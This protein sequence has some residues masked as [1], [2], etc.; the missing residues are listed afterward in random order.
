[1]SNYMPYTVQ[2]HNTYTTVITIPHSSIESIDFI[3]GNDPTETLSSVYNRL[4]QKPQVL[5]NG[6]LFTLAT[7]QNILS[8]IDEGREQNYS[9]NYEGI[10]I[11]KADVTTLVYGHDKD[12]WK[13]F[14]A[15][16]PMLVKDGTAITQYTQA[17]EINY[18][19]A[20]QSIGITQDSDVVIITVDKPGIKFEGLAKIMVQY[21]VYYGMA[22]DGGGSVRTM[23]EGKVINTPTENRPVDNMVAIY[24][25]PD[26]LTCVDKDDIG[27]WALDDVRYCYEHE[28]MNGD[29]HNRFRPQDPITRQ[30][31]ACVAARLHRQCYK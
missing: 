2:K 7:G 19:A 20:R 17:N 21:G 26:P 22:L 8:F 29:N 9:N 30:E 24:I 3:K 31:L 13:D 6:G 14:L 4:S 18:T 10:G 28:L 15:S 1:M 25:K 5:I 16:Y 27:A 23:V 11:K 12:G